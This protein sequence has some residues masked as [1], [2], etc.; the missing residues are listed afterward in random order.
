LTLSCA[1]F[2]AFVARANAA[3]GFLTGAPFF[4]ARFFPEV[5]FAAVFFAEAFFAEV[6]LAVAFLDD[7]RLVVMISISCCQAH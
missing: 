5:F 2:F 7:L 6:F 1:G 4:A 3:A